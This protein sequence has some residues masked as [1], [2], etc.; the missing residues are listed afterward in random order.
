MI[1]YNTFFCLFYWPL[2]HWLIL[3]PN[4][5]TNPN[6]NNNNNTNPNPNHNTK[7][8]SN[9]DPTHPWQWRR[10]GEKSRVDKRAPKAREHLGGVRGHATPGKFWNIK[11]LKCYFLHFELRFYTILN[12]AKRRIKYSKENKF[13]DWNFYF[14]Y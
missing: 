1:M 5:N 7:T 12:D 10:Q 3:I 6:P 13:Q 4:N 8:N 11:S 2:V 9:P 14:S